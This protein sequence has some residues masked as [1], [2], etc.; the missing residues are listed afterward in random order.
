MLSFKQGSIKYHFLSL[1]HDSTCDW[2]RVSWAIG[3]HCNHDAN[4]RAGASGVMDIVVGNGY[5]DAS[6][7]PGRDW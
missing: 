1:W 3:K 4:V 7:N 5:A 6:S 2:T